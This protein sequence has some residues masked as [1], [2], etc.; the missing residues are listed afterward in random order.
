MMHLWFTGDLR[1]AFS[2]HAPTKELGLAGLLPKAFC[3][4]GT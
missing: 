2:T 3:K 4:V 1:S